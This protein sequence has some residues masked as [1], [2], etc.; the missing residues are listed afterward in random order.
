M[1][2]LALEGQR[3]AFEVIAFEKHIQTEINGQPINLYI[4]RI[5]RLANGD[6]IIIDYKTGS[7]DPK[8]WFGQRPENPQLPLYALTAEKTPAA[9]AYGIVRDDGCLYRGVVRRGGLLPDLPP[10]ETNATRFLV[11][12]GQDLPATIS[13]WRQ[14][15]EQL[16]KDF[17][18]GEAGVN[19]KAGLKTCSAS[20]CELQSLCRVGEL[21]QQRKTSLEDNRQGPSS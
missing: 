17:Q 1:N 3:E 9:V 11:E 19:P 4:D 8:K 20:Y 13:E 12:A 15:L 10:K 14:I 5:D 21:E 6:E 18:A 7:E 2:Y 16:M